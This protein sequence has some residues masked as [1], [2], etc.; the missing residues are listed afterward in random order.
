MRPRRVEHRENDQSERVVCDREQE[1][2]RNRRM[3]GRGIS[4]CDHR[5]EGDIGCARNR[6]ATEPILL[7]RVSR[8]AR[9]KSALAHAMP[10]T[11]AA[12]GKRAC[13]RRERSLRAVWP[14]TPPSRRAQRRTPCRCRSPRSAAGGRRRRSSRYRCSPTRPP[15]TV[16]TSNRSELSR[17]N[18]ARP[19]CFVFTTASSCHQRRRGL[20]HP[21]RAGMP[22]AAASD[23][24]GGTRGTDH[25][26]RTAPNR[27]SNHS[28][29]N[30]SAVVKSISPP[31]RSRRPEDSVPA[32]QVSRQRQGM[33]VE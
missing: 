28:A 14:R 15:A 31:V 19:G 3:A 16:P 21:A 24:R 10:P 32:A 30:T 22:P 18:R 6:P 12:K 17:M 9:R 4:A 13:R 1:Q 26:C 27:P 25:R 33:C 5:R 29:S 2:K 7:A 20:R 11:A 23:R 8:P